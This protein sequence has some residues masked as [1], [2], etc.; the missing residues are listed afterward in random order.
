MVHTGIFATKAECD[1]KAG[2]L[3]DTAG[4][5]ETNINL[6]CLMS[7]SEINIECKYNFSDNYGSLNADV[8]SILSCLSSDIVALY[9]RNYN[10]TFSTETRSNSEDTIMVLA[11][12]IE[13]LKKLL[14]DQDQITYIKGA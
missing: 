9:G 10:Y 11:Y 6:W 12:R 13:V 5:V 14:R 7:E 1:S 8:K 3:V 2:L 4:W